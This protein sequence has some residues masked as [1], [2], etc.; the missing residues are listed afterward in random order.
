M[1]ADGPFSGLFRSRMTDLRL[2]NFRI[3]SAV[4]G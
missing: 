4:Q 3:L 1:L 2:G